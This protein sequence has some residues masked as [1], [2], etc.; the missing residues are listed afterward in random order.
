MPK[1]QFFN[2]SVK[3]L[4]A[5]YMPHASRLLRMHVRI[6]TFLKNILLMLFKL[7]KNACV[8]RQAPWW[9]GDVGGQKKEASAVSTLFFLADPL[10]FVCGGSALCFCVAGPLF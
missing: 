5:Y 4:H 1:L 8:Y 2:R 10:F 7:K 6:Y 3:T 9:P